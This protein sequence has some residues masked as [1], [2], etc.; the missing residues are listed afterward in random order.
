MGMPESCL[1][2]VQVLVDVGAGMGYFSLAAAARGHSVIAFELATKSLVSFAA[3]MRHNNLSHAI[4]LHQVSCGCKLDGP[5]FA[6]VGPCSSTCSLA[7]DE[8][9]VTP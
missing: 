7:P 9:P 2:G 5:G 6:R 4:T 8:Y 3:S 1:D